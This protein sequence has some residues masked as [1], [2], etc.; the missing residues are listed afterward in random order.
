MM[1][2][3]IRETIQG[4]LTEATTTIDQTDLP[5][6]YNGLK[7]AALQIELE[8]E[9]KLLNAML[10]SESFEQ[11]FKVRCSLRETDTQETFSFKILPESP[12]NELYWKIAQLV[13]TPQT[14]QVML[15]ILLP[16]VNT[17]LQVTIPDELPDTL[18]KK[19][20]RQYHKSWEPQLQTEN[21]LQKFSASPTLKKLNDYLIVENVIL[22]LQDIANLPLRTHSKLQ[23]K[24]KR[25]NPA[26]AKTL[27]DHN[28]DLASLDADISLF[29]SAGITPKEAIEQLI[30]GLWLGSTKFTDSDIATKEATEAVSRFFNYF[31][32]LSQEI[33]EELK[34]LK[35]DADHT[36]G[37]ILDT[38]IKQGE[39]VEESAVYLQAFLRVNDKNKLL[40][41]SPKM[42]EEELNRLEKKY[43][44]KPSSSRPILNVQKEDLKIPLPPQLIKQALER[45]TLTPENLIALIINFPP[46]FYEML[47]QSIVLPDP[48]NNLAEL[49]SAIG[50]GF[51]T[52]P[53][54]QAT[55][56]A[57]SS[58]Y[59]RF[60][61]QEPFFHWLLQ[62]EDLVLINETI[63]SWSDD[64]KIK[65]LKETNQSGETIF[66]QAIDNLDLLKILLA[67]CSKEQFLEMIR[68]PDETGQ[69][70]LHRFVKKEEALKTVL[71]FHPDVELVKADL[72]LLDKK[73]QT[74][75][76][77]ATCNSKSLETLLALCPEEQ[78]L[79]ILLKQNKEGQTVLDN[80]IQNPKSLQ[81]A[82][83]L[84][85]QSQFIQVV[86]SPKILTQVLKKPDSLLI[87]LEACP[88][89][90]RLEMMQIKTENDPQILQQVFE[91]YHP[92][93]ISKL[94]MLLPMLHRLK[95]FQ[96]IRANQ[97]SMK[98]LEIITTVF[99]HTDIVLMDKIIH[100]DTSLHNLLQPL[101]EYGQ[102]LAK[103]DTEKG[104]TVIK[105][106]NKLN[107]TINEFYTNIVASDSDEKKGQ[108]FAA[109]KRDFKIKLHSKDE[110]M[111]THRKKWKPILA[112]ILLGIG[113]FGTAFLAMLIKAATGYYSGKLHFNNVCFFAHTQ[114]EQQ[115]EA[116]Q[117]RLDSLDC[118]L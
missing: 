47:W 32:A 81:A 114:R 102:Q 80:A 38:K 89:E 95:A 13:F 51:F 15:S 33:Q 73:H 84:L 41:V 115:I 66:D 28:T 4:Y 97:D 87:L 65:A 12:A 43:N 83:S 50:L 16:S 1:N 23:N 30:Q 45:M 90:Q 31:E 52:L 76:H 39:C 7:K 63:A 27:Y 14:T 46:S 110:E 68:I 42:S 78:R 112:N 17:H 103:E 88:E 109:F 8:K 91:T 117:Q 94:I 107:Q 26:L 113:T 82:L 40:H 86:R 37:Y 108:I 20:L 9:V 99:P 64:E 54:R 85:P 11:A 19:E 105:L 61:L 71:T 21:S 75:F 111:Q 2:E 49:A 104:E 5:Y 58:H 59:S 48:Q 60:N 56:K 57:I 116:T 55:I 98:L 72:L 44:F 62:T 24:L 3:I 29:N 106:V 35:Y 74:V 93:K 53:Q 92:R 101:K 6:S 34:A 70:V 96:S 36:L 100:E 118:M 18:S 69:T 67:L 10:L 77:T 79:P 25:L 22:D